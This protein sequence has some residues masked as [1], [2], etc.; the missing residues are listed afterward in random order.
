[1]NATSEELTHERKKR[2]YTWCA[3]IILTQIVMVSI[4]TMTPIHMGHHGHGLAEVGLVI[5]FHIGAMYLPSLITGILVDKV[6]RIVMAIAATIIFLLSVV[7]AATAP[8]DSMVML[9]V[10]LS[11]LDLGRNFG[12]FRLKL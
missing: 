12:F 7:I 3:N 2:N 1:M 11:L 6:G 9:L 5:G 10:A 4:M 8:A